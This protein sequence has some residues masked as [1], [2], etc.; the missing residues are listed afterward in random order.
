MKRVGFVGWRGM[1]GSVLMERM[2]AE[3]DFDAVDPVFFSTS[4]VGGQAPDVG[5]EAPPLGDAKDVAALKDL[6]VI[7]TCQG[8]DYTNAVYPKLRE[9][10]FDGYWIDAAS[11]LRMKDHAAIILDPVN[12]DVIDQSLDAGVKDYIGGNCTVS[13]MLMA[14]AGLFQQGWVEWVSS[15]TYQA[16]SGAGAKNMRELVA[17]MRALGLAAGDALDDPASQILE[18]DR[19]VLDTLRSDDFPTSAF[20]AP[21]AGSLLGWIDKPV[22][23]LAWL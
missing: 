20:G 3:K 23:L 6:D 2:R 5:K 11:A 22:E 14:M 4:Q 9:A 13:L 12:R 7:I 21:L 15:M 10:G 8:G 18:I 19:A 17:Q 1:V 16:A